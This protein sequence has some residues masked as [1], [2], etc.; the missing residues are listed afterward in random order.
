MSA[1]HPPPDLAALAWHSAHRRTRAW[2][3]RRITP[4]L[5]ALLW[6]L[7]L[8]VVAMLGVVAWQIL[9]LP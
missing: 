1:T 6:A 2:P 5:A 7:R 9:H 8:Y 3:A 4:G